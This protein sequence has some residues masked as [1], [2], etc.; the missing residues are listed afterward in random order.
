MLHDSRVQPD[1]DFREIAKRVRRLDPRVHAF[2]VTQQR[3]NLAAQLAQLLRPT[4]FVE[5]YRLPKQRYLRGHVARGG[6][7]SKSWAYRRLDAAGLPVPRWVEIVEGLRLD[8]A[9]WGPYVVVKPDLGFRGASV[10]AAKTAQVRFRA[11]ESYPEH[12][13]GRLG[14]MLAQR[15]IYTGAHPVAYR[16]LTC[17]GEPIFAQRWTGATTQPPLSGP[18]G[19][20][21]GQR[22]IVASARGA[23]TMLTEEAD[24]LAFARRIHEVFP[25]APLIGSDILR[26]V[27][28]GELWIAEIN[29]HDVW[30]LNSP[31]GIAVQASTGIDLY[32]QF[33]ALD[34]AA[35]AMLRATRRLAR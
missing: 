19:F 31:A 22:G 12:H 13:L 3:R 16:A 5:F 9:E 2:V 11:A 14:A 21:E 1:R 33:G 30:A 7:Y 17:F 8:P 27:G 15:F 25:D 29:M 34:R 4:L 6:E 20:A 35:E 24:I 32:G 28:T 10:A 18:A 23:S 26:E